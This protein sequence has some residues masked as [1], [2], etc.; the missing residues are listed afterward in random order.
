MSQQTNSS[1]STIA[2]LLRA[3]ENIQF[4]IGV[5][6]AAEYIESPSLHEIPMAP[7]YCKNILFWRGIIVPVIDIKQ[8][9]GNPKSN[10][11]H[12]VMV[13]A[14]QIKD[15]SPIDHIAF[16][17]EAAP[18]KIE[19]HDENSCDLP[20]NYPE[21]LKPYVMSLFKHNDNIASVFNIAQLSLGNLKTA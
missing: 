21:L 11:D 3:A 9:A 15:N 12:I 2:W 17:L 4:C 7:A 6:Q 16:V 18:Q 5:H 1:N 14:Y 13:T 19:V 10:D 8:L 20:E